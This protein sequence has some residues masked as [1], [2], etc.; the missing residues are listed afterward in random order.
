VWVAVTWAVGLLTANVERLDVAYGSLASVMVLLSW[1]YLSA[2]AFL[3]G[4]LVNAVL[5]PEPA[6]R[7]PKRVAAPLGAPDGALGP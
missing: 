5:A 6:E 7:A 1:F 4:G 3:L 2:F